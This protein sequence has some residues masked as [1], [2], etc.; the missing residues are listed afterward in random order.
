MPVVLRQG[1]LSVWLKVQ[2]HAQKA[3]GP[4]DRASQDPNDAGELSGSA[5]L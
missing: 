2:F 1:M 4:I 5:G 3:L